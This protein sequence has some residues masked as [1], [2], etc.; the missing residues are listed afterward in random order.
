M[1]VVCGRNL[2]K[3]E[4][5]LEPFSPK[6]LDKRREI[7]VDHGDLLIAEYCRMVT[8]EID[9][10]S[11]HVFAFAR[12]IVTGLRV[13][14]GERVSV[15][16]VDTHGDWFLTEVTLGGRRRLYMS[17]YSV[18]L[19]TPAVRVDA[20]LWTKVKET[21]HVTSF[22]LTAQ[23]LVMRTM[24]LGF[25]VM[26]GGKV[27]AYDGRAKNFKIFQHFC[28]VFRHFG[29]I[30]RDNKLYFHDLMNGTPFD[31]PQV[32][33]SSPHVRLSE[34]PRYDLHARRV[35]RFALVEGYEYFALYD[36]TGEGGMETPVF[37]DRM[38]FA[39]EF[40]M[41]LGFLEIAHGRFSRTQRIINGRHYPIHMDNVTFALFHDYNYTYIYSMHAGTAIRI[42]HSNYGSVAICGNRLV[43]FH[44]KLVLRQVALYG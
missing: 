19:P 43:E 23:T 35:L 8:R 34:P 13:I 2:C 44:L 27:Y 12:P 31:A 21:F 1:G 9:L 17:S 24:E 7:P 36:S 3:S 30:V 33:R 22:R 29:I 14:P 28:A 4:P 26:T 6:A 40:Q 38:K 25:H 32:L 18:V 37:F 5:T 20:E 42:L 39:D 10:L 11:V 41:M 16:T 15:R